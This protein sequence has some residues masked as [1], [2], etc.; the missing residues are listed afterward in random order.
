VSATEVALAWV[1]DRPGVSAPVVGSRTVAQLRAALASEEL[2]L[3]LEIV[4]ALEEIS[5]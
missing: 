1:R 2:E 5:D 3:P 4:D